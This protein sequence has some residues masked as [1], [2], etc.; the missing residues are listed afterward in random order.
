MPL[1]CVLFDFDGVLVDTENRNMDYLA[2]ALKLHGVTLTKD[3]R[4][5]L[6]GRN[7]PAFIQEILNRAEE[8]VT[9]EEFLED[10]KRCGNVYENGS[11]FQ[12]IPGAK[13]F[14][15][16]LRYHGFQIGL[17]SSTRTQLII[18]ALNR[19]GIVSF[20]DCIVCGDMV[21]EKK[22]APDCYNKALSLLSIPAEDAVI[23]EDSP[24]GI[25]AAQAAGISV[26]GFKGGEICQD[27][28]AADFEATSFEEIYKL[29]VF[30]SI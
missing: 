13:S 3:D 27:T 17:V 22:P 9:M 14:L 10:R 20:F 7:D 1:K 18:T 26:I 4:R 8:N 12:L 29:S 19:L 24:L 15:K 28:S 5:N 6:I 25:Q 11:D 21:A 30:D 2:A 16:W 23:I